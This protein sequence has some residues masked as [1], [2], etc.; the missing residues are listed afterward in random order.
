[1]DTLSLIKETKILPVVVFNSIEEVNVKLSALLEGGI[2]AAEICFRTECSPDALK[3]AIKNFSNMLIGAG[4]IIDRNQCKL[5]IQLG[6]KF[7]VS[8]GFS[9][10]V[11]KECLKNNILYIP[12]AVTPTEIMNL[13]SKGINYIKFFPA[14]SFGGLKAIKDLASAFP[15]VHFMPT[16]GVNNDNLIEYITFKN[17]FAVGGSWLLKG[18]IVKNC[19]E[20]KWIVERGK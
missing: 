7:I 16:G 12:G 9:E 1:M 2:N 3:M 15:N 17:I 5:A 19:Q 11:N 4:T 20:A 8:P 18:D 13:L 6:A 10:E 14:G